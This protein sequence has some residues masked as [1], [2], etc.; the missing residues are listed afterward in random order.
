MKTTLNWHNG[1]QNVRTRLGRMTVSLIVPKAGLD[2][3]IEYLPHGDHVTVS[4]SRWTA[5]EAWPDGAAEEVYLEHLSETVPSPSTDL[6][7]LLRISAEQYCAHFHD[8]TPGFEV[9]VLLDY[10][11]D[12][13]ILPFGGGVDVSWALPF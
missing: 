11:A 8:G 1:A 10:L 7:C 3:E 5:V 9:R 4:G 6:L 2:L 12:M 13:G